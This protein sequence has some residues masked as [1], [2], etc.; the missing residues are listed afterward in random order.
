MLSRNEIVRVY[1]WVSSNDLIRTPTIPK[2]TKSNFRLLETSIKDQNSS[3]HLISNKDSIGFYH[4]TGC[5]LAFKREP[6]YQA[7]RIVFPCANVFE[8]LMPLK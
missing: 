8:C 1:T 5:F 2:C 3:T 6:N 7:F 4:F